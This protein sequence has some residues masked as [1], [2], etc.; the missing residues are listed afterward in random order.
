MVRQIPRLAI[1]MMVKSVITF[2]IFLIAIAILVPVFTAVKLRG[3]RSINQPV[4]QAVLEESQ[5]HWMVK[6]F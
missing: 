3:S 4:T 1:I 6:L 2:T 5:L